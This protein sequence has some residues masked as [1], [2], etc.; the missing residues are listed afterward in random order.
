MYLLPPTMRMTLRSYS[1]LR[2]P[3]LLAE[4]HCWLSQS[5]SSH[6]FACGQVLPVYNYLNDITRLGLFISS[7]QVEVFC[8]LLEL[9]WALHCRHDQV[10]LAYVVLGSGFIHHL[11]PH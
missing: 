3:V 7:L 8:T 10:N 4:K 11:P 1:V 9:A 5:G 6:R 2:N